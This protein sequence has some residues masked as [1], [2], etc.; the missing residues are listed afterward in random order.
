MSSI[1]DDAVSLKRSAIADSLRRQIVSG[2]FPPGMKLPS[3][4]EL[5]REFQVSVDTTQR[6]VQELKRQRF[7]TA[8]RRAG[9]FVAQHPPHLFHYGL[10]YL[11]GEPAREVSNFWGALADAADAFEPD[12]P[13][14]VRVFDQVVVE[15]TESYERLKRYVVNRRLA[16]L[17][18]STA[19]NQLT[20]TPVVAF[21][22]IPRIAITQPIGC[23]PGVKP[24]E[25][26]ESKL[27]DA[28]MSAFAQ[29]GRR[30]IAVISFG[31]NATLT[32]KLAQS[33][34]RFGLVSHPRWLHAPVFHSVPI[35]NCAS[36]LFSEHQEHRP[37]GLL[38]LDD[39][40]VEPA[41][42]GLVAAGVRVPDDVTVVAHANFPRLT[43]SHVPAVRVGWNVPAL[44]SSCVDA[45]ANPNTPIPS[46]QPESRQP[47]EE[48]L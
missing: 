43:R 47:E 37:D 13:R 8:K 39:N 41:T 42:E 46:F 9:T 10:V 29:R 15:Q 25:L 36:I 17:I 45:L 18:F 27:F 33:M 40:F 34:S 38:I 44:L 3:R 14:R 12:G 28:A 21:P 16:G 30:R 31:L 35:R 20:N 4:E 11:A 5:S 26:S 32:E 24:M 19:P 7:V 48:S 22:G 2:V 23:P 6:A 1:N